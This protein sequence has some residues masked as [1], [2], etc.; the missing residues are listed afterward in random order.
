MTTIKAF[1]TAVDWGSL[2]PVVLFSC[3]RL[4]Q[5]RFITS[6]GAVKGHE[7]VLQSL[8][9]LDNDIMTCAVC[10]CRFSDQLPQVLGNKSSSLCSLSIDAALL[11]SHTSSLA[12]NEA[13][14]SSCCNLLHSFLEFL[15]RFWDL[16]LCQ[17]AVVNHTKLETEFYFKFQMTVI[18]VTAHH[19]WSLPSA[20]CFVFVC[21]KANMP[22]N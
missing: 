2:V 11:P 10:P 20:S 15:M 7:W 6:L 4:E 18:T 9:W 21:Q 8:P 19:I 3:G 17:N 16:R 13:D 22:Q 1:I 12:G 5:L 14:H